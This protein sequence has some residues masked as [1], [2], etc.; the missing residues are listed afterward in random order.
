MVK[1]KVFCPSSGCYE[2]FFLKQAGN[3]L[4]V[5]I[6]GR[7]QRGRGLGGFLGSIGRAIIPMVKSAGKVLLKE[8]GKAGLQV[9]GDVVRGKNLKSSI[10]NQAKASGARLLK[11][12]IK[13]NSSAPP[14]KRIKRAEQAVSRQKRGKKRRYT[15]IFN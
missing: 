15:D 5:F 4:P 7:A 14:A 11:R 13:D 8:G 10:K 3:G 2:N 1:K 9:L 6:G 12:A